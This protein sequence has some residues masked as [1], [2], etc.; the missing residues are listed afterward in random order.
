LFFAVEELLQKN[1][2]AAASSAIATR[3]ASAKL[4]FSLGMFQFL[5][6]RVSS[7]AAGKAA[8]RSTASHAAA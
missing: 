7:A 2:A 5:P 4:F 8:T 1:S 6:V 3:T